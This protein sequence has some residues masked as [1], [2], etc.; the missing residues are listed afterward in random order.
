[1]ADTDIERR[2]I[3]IDT[4]IERCACDKTGKKKA[5]IRGYAALYNSDSVD[6]GGF[7]E[8][9]LPGAFDSVMKRGTDVVALYNHDPAFLLGRESSGTLRLSVDDRGLRYEIDAPESRADVVEAIERGDVRGSSFAFRV[10][11]AQENWSRMADGK[12]LREI[13][14]V[15]GLFDVGPVM[16]PAYGATE[17][18]VS[19]RALDMAKA[20]EVF[21]LE[22]PAEMEGEQEDSSVEEV[23][24]LSPNNYDLHEAIEKIADENGQW[25]QAGVDGAHY[26]EQSPF[27]AQ[28]IKCANCVFWNPEGNCDVVA[29]EI[30]EAG[31]CKLW[32]IPEQKLAQA[33]AVGRSEGV[34]LERAGESRGDVAAVAKAAAKALEAAARVANR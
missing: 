33:E 26:I 30:K 10:K 22:A 11:P 21:D 32:I 5:V 8:R 27:A 24:E 23:G 18:F 14:E 19:R 29:G 20:E 13:R 16:K 17:S 2:L 15:D 25:P 4:V 34:D 31:V 3:E 7:T 6:L 9:I 28:G 1:M 12:Q